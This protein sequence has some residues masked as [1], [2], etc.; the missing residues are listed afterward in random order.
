MGPVQTSPS[1]ARTSYNADDDTV[2]RCEYDSESENFRKR[3]T[4]NGA[5]GLRRN[6]Q[7]LWNRNRKKKRPRRRPGNSRLDPYSR[8]GTKS[9]ASARIERDYW[10]SAEM[11]GRYNGDD[12]FNRF[13][14]ASE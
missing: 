9:S 4:A 14:N 2:R 1:G 5:K 12:E 11:E 6:R 10:G 8:R 13:I 3:N 7:G